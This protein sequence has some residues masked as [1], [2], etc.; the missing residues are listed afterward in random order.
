MIVCHCKAVSERAIRRAIRSG[1]S[2]PLRVGQTC[3][4]GSV[5]GGCRPVVEDLLADEQS[6]REAFPA[7]TLAPAR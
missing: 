4:A 6:S 1:A 2:C 7:L 3:G 5:C